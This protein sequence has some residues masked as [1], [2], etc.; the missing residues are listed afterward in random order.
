MGTVGHTGLFVVEPAA[1][2]ADPDR[3]NL[4]RATG[5][6]SF[7]AQGPT[8]RRHMRYVRGE[9]LGSGLH[10]S[11]TMRRGAP[12]ACAMANWGERPWHSAHA[13]KSFLFSSYFLFQVFISH[14]NSKFQFKSS[15][16]I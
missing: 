16:K 2:I 15:F 12:M 11:D 8:R 7:C 4:L 3:A 1:G 6:R 9:V 10:R 13:G 14:F 5:R